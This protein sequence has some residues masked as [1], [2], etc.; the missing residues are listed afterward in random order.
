METFKDYV[1]LM[2]QALSEI[3]EAIPKSHEKLYLGGTAPV[4]I[5]HLRHAISLDLDFHTNQAL[6]PTSLEARSL[7]KHFKGR[8]EWFEADHEFGIF[9]GA[10][11][12]GEIDQNGGKIL[13]EIDLFS[14]FED[15]P[16]ELLED[17]GTWSK[18]KTTSLHAY[19]KNK[20]T[21][22]EERAEAKDL[23]HLYCLWKER[24][25]STKVEREL[26]KLDPVSIE[27]AKATFNRDW[28]EAKTKIRSLKG[29]KRL[30]EKA[31][32]KW[33]DAL[34]QKKSRKPGER[35]DHTIH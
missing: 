26:S 18:F 25:W 29:L 1:H 14:H 22:L 15:T 16:N 34:G 12:S 33:V 8:L 35:N 21:C 5:R 3:A 9:R 10:I 11:D 31:L 6:A 28:R 27:K 20:V 23:Y 7:K 32:C 2:Q 19:L 13:I 4:S 17:G 24:G 30:D